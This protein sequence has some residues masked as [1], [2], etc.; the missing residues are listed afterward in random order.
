MTE[1]SRNASRLEAIFWIAGL[2]LVALPSPATEPWIT[3]CPLAHLGD[4]LGFHFCP[5]CGLGRSVAWLVRGDLPAS[6]AMHPLGIPAVV[7]LGSHAV[8]L[9]FGARKATIVH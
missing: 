3:I 6:L 5:G 1:R 4:L 2:V 8:R 7:I 9:W